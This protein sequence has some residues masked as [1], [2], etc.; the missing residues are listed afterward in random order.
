MKDQL[1]IKCLRYEIEI[2]RKIKHNRVLGLLELYEGENN[3]Y[4]L[5]E[6]YEG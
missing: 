2:M 5:C 1:E 4:C 3:I 6:Y